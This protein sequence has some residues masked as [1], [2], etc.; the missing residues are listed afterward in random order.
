M[1]AKS[2]AVAAFVLA[3]VAF[4]GCRATNSVKPPAS[5]SPI[6]RGWRAVLLDWSDNGKFDERHACAAVREAMQHLPSDPPTYNT[7]YDDL[8]QYARQVC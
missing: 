8:R 5:P 1:R 3:A 7:A 2:T 4:G 6:V